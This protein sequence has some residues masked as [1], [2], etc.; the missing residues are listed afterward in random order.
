MLFY[1]YISNSVLCILYIIRVI[2][3][4]TD[5]PAQVDQRWM[6]TVHRALQRQYAVHVSQYPQYHHVQR[7][8]DKQQTVT[9]IVIFGLLP[10]GNH[11][12]DVKKLQYKLNIGISNTVY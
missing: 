9:S 10:Y 3:H 11:T 2:R 8:D 12:R 7:P 4:T 6:G 1:F 5:H